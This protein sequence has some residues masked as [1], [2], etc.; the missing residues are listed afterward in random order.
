MKWY[1]IQTKP[2]SHL[3]A[4]KNLKQQGFEVFLP[5]ISKTTRT[6]K[7]FAS[8]IVPLFPGYLFLG[9]SS[10]TI[11]WKS[12]NATRGVSKA[13][14]LDGKYRPISVTI[15]NGLKNRCDAN[16]LI[17]LNR[18]MVAGDRIK[19]GKGP[20]SEFVCEIEKVSE[21]QRVWVLIELMRQKTRAQ[22]QVDDISVIN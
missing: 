11:S 14:T 3:T 8:K 7:K 15:I 19:I 6:T 12:I 22:I 10:D 16:S 17:K 1:L 5:L 20:F 9:C 18:N 13:V 4:S 21:N 2:N